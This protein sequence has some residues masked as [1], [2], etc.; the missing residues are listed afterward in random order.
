M[1]DV[2]VTVPVAV[3]VYT[4]HVVPLRVTVVIVGDPVVLI[5]PR[6]ARA[7]V[8]DFD[9]FSPEDPA[10]VTLTAQSPRTP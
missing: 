2:S 5:F 7:S 10:V 4:R 1:A 6:P 3:N 9:P 8:F